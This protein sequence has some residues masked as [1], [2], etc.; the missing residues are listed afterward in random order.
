MF[1]CNHEI[2]LKKTKYKIEKYKNEI[3]KFK[4]KTRNKKR[5]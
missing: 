2:S 3:I 5:P 1:K 4:K